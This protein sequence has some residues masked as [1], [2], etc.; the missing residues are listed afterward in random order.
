MCWGDVELLRKANG[1]EYLVFS[2][3]QTKTR[4]GDSTRDVRPIKPKMYA[5]PESQKC[6]VAAYKLYAEK[7]PAE[8]NTSEAPFYLAINNCTKK[9]SSKPWLKKSAVG[10]NKLTH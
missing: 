10:V 1:Q 7:R 6:P 8:M 9:Y 3:R 4:P 2:E 5:V